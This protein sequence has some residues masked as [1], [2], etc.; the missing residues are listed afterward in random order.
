M[1]AITPDWTK[2]HFDGNG[3]RRIEAHFDSADTAD[4]WAHG[5]PV[6]VQES[7]DSDGA[8]V[9]AKCASS[10]G[11]ATFTLSGNGDALRVHIWGPQ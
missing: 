6:V 7:A 3:Q 5:I 9:S 8:A 1:A 10:S 4:T 11:T 2:I